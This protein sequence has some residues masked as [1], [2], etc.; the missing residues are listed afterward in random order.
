MNGSLDWV[1]KYTAEMFISCQVHLFT[2]RSKKAG[3]FASGVALS[4]R[5]APSFSQKSFKILKTLVQIWIVSPTFA[6]RNSK[7]HG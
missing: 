2:D 4:F 3:S 6:V 5:N 1:G 7:E